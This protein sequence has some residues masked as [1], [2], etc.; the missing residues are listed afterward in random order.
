MPCRYWLSHFREVVWVR[1]IQAS[2]HTRWHTVIE[3]KIMHLS[4]KS[5]SN[6]VAAALVI[7]GGI[8][9][10]TYQTGTA[11][12]Y[13][14]FTAADAINN[15]NV[16]QTGKGYYR[17]PEIDELHGLRPFG[18]AVLV[19]GVAFA[20]LILYRSYQESSNQQVS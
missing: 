19:I 3:K 7:V 1:V 5:L 8:F 16:E 14:N 18:V 6:L 11:E 9:L 13:D 20:S 10:F 17:Y 4:N 15:I 12:N 2:W